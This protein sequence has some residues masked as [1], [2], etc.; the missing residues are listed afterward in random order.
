M[1]DR[2][3]ARAIR[4][5]GELLKEI[6]PAKNQHDA[7]ARVGSV[8][9]SRTQAATDAGMSERQR[10]TALRVAN[11]PSEEFEQAVESDNLPTVTALAERGKA[12]STS[13]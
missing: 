3:Q 6:E 10:K 2:I 9:S 7:N 11:V 1:A 8:P 5:C 4:R 12:K 13:S